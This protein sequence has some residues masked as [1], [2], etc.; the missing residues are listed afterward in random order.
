MLAVRWRD[1]GGVQGRSPCWRC[2]GAARPAA[3]A[4]E[5]SNG[6]PSEAKGETQGREGARRAKASNRAPTRGRGEEHSGDGPLP[7]ARGTARERG[8]GATGPRPEGDEKERSEAERG[9]PAEPATSRRSRHTAAR[10]EPGHCLATCG[11]ACGFTTSSMSRRSR[12]P[13]V[14][15]APRRH[16]IPVRALSLRLLRPLD[17]SDERSL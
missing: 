12:G 5:R 6:A 8:E 15:E 14:A 16:R 2:G 1:S 13:Q 11:S 17:S 7:P 10:A 4:A 9:R 3:L